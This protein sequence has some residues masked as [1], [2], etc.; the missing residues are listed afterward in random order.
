MGRIENET[1]HAKRILHD[2]EGIW[3]WSSPAG[4]MRAG[5]RAGAIL[6]RGRFSPSDSL[7]EIGCGT[8]LFTEK[9]YRA[10]KAR[11]TAIDLSQ[12]LLE[13]ARRRDGL[14]GVCFQTGNGM[15]LDF[16]E[17]RFDGVYGNSVL[18]HLEM[19][20]ALRE[21]FRVLKRGGRLVFIEPNLC[22]P[23]ILI[24]KKI[25][26]FKRMAGDSPD[27]TAIL[28]WKLAR[29][30]RQIGF[31]HVRISPCDFL[32]P[33]TPAFL[34]GTAQK[35]GSFLEKIPLFREIAGSVVIYGEKR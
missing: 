35:M 31:E 3:G 25:P 4:K 8:G 5:R 34:I 7:L 10:L 15:E 33:A 13:M 28:R 12:D 11:I 30:M 20:T 19:K 22:N 26:F 24:Q 16:E 23:Q 27:E 1:L 21:I 32:H 9:I 6:Q 17:G 2:P 14:E 29:E 18:H